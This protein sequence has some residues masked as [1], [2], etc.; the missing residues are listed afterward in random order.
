MEI[1]GN[2]FLVAGLGV[3]G[4]AVTRFLTT[5]GGRV[6]VTDRRGEDE[7]GDAV[8]EIRAMGAATALGGHDPGILG[9]AGAVS[10]VILSPGVPHTLPFLASARDRGIEVMGEIEL[11]ARFIET[12]LAAVTGT[13]GKTTTTEWI[14]E[15]LRRSGRTVFVGGN[16]GTPLIGFAD[17]GQ[18]AGIAVVELSSFQLDTIQRFRPNVAVLLNIT[19]DHLD[20]Y[21]DMAAYARSKARIFENQQEGDAAV[22][23]GTDA[24]TAALAEVI[25]AGVDRMFFRSDGSAADA[26]IRSGAKNAASLLVIRRPD[27]EELTFDLSRSGAKNAAPLP[28]GRHNL[29]NLAAAAL[30][31]LCMGAV[32]SGIQAAI[33]EFKAPD[34]RLTH[35]ATIDG[36]RF[37]DD[38][39]ATNVDAVARALDAFDAPILLIMGGR[40]KGGGFRTLADAVRKKVKG[41][42]LMGEAADVLKGDLGDRV[43]TRMTESMDEAVQEAFRTADP[44]DVVL[45]S[46]ACASF[47]MY[48][49]YAQRGEDFRRCVIEQTPTL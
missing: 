48:A 11:A 2:H 34:H 8:R 35:V 5:R 14:G 23:N 12:P 20:R 46:P 6:T 33:N 32:P 25:P 43:P 38:S 49:S 16:I 18:P 17:A 40:T 7:I 30:A 39:K 45:L 28:P 36:V 9:N 4:L 15:M 42:F 13:N 29:E 1:R 26:G 41:L 37:Y 44:G 47:D 31:A 22:L 21:P 3:S 27:G 24:R 19:A 10:G